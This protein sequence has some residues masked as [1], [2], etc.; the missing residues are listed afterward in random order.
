MDYSRL[1]DS[2]TAC[3]FASHGQ[4]F[5]GAECPVCGT[6]YFPAAKAEDCLKEHRRRSTLGKTKICAKCKKP[7]PEDE[8][9]RTP[10]KR[11]RRVICDS[12]RNNTGYK[13]RK[14]RINPDDPTKLEVL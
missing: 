7:R 12:C 14:K 1:N 9:R 3:K 8:F 13:K 11:K 10:W 4:T 2:P 5:H 6:K